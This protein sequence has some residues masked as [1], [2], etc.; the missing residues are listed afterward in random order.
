MQTE[1]NC[2]EYSSFQTQGN[3]LPPQDKQ[4]GEWK[5]KTIMKIDNA[6]EI[7]QMKCTQMQTE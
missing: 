7:K 3:A 5:C 2:V 6:K 4:C 1:N